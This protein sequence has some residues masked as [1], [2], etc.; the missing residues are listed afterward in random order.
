METQLLDYEFDLTRSQ[1]AYPY[2]D[3]GAGYSGE[4]QRR[5]IERKYTLTRKTPSEVD[6]PENRQEYV[7]AVQVYHPGLND[8]DA[9][10]YLLDTTAYPLDNLS[11]IRDSL[12]R[13]WF[14]SLDKAPYLSLV[15]QHFPGRPEAELVM[16]LERSGF[17]PGAEDLDERLAAM[18]GKKARDEARAEANRARIA[19]VNLEKDRQWAEDTTAREGRRAAYR[20]KLARDRKAR[21]ETELERANARLA[22]E[23]AGQGN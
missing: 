20:L 9:L 16:L 13:A 7:A 12:R 6:H 23:L 21:A 1:S 18:A 14:S 3:E 8:D 11:W 19:A 17:V 10:T 5:Q 2:G 22:E 15:E 4:E